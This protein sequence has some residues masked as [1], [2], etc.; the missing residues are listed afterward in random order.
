MTLW[1]NTK[2]NILMLKLMNDF[3]Y[4]TWIISQICTH[5]Q[6]LWYDRVVQEVEKYFGQDLGAGT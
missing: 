1:N 5:M 2:C 4:V 3:I 6:S